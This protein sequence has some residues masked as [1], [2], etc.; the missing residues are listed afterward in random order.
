MLEW[1]QEAGVAWHFIAPGKPMQNGICEAFNGRMRDEFLNE[2]LFG[3]LRHARQLIEAWRDDYNHHRP[4]TSL[5]R[6]TPREYFNRSEKDQTGFVAQR[7][8]EGVMSG[9][10]FILRI[11]RVSWSA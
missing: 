9:E 10:G 5:D 1:T 6:L 7:S 11:Q 2:T 4:H 3:G 8:G